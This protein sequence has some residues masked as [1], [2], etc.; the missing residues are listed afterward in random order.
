MKHSQ[1][2]KYIFMTCMLLVGIASAFILYKNIRPSRG[3]PYEEATMEQAAEYMTYEKNYVLL[4]VS[5]EEAFQAE[6]MEE[7]LNVPYEKL[8][9][10]STLTLPDKVQMVYVC[11][12]DPEEAR[13]AARKLCELGYKNI[14]LI[15]AGED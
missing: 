1:I 6:H 7:A 14:T 12:Q 15:T 2:A 10:R 11:G 8:V 4:D 3:V 13:K 5:S 9:E